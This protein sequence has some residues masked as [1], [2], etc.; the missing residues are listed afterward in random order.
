MASES[1]WTTLASEE[2]ISVHS[3]LIYEY[4]ETESIESHRVKST[5]EPE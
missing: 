5:F 1:G 2:I 3:E 4:M